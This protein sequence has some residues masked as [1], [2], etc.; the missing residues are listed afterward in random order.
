MSDEVK[1]RLEDTYQ[2]MAADYDSVRRTP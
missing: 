1:A 2:E